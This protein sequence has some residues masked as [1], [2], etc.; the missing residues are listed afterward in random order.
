MGPWARGAEASTGVALARSL[1]V[2][3]LSAV[4]RWLRGGGGAVAHRVDDCGEHRRE[5]KE[6]SEVEEVAEADLAPRRESRAKDAPVVLVRDLL[7]AHEPAQALRDERRDARGGEL[8]RA[9]LRREADAVAVKECTCGDVDILC[10]HR[11]V[12]RILLEHAG[13]PHRTAMRTSGL[14]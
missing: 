8:A 9:R 13:T 11:R 4:A 10:Q 3:H 2:H 5:E 7:P 14:A 1:G 12:E 6:P